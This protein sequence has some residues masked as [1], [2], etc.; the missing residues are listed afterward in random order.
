[1]LTTLEKLVLLGGLDGLNDLGYEDL[2]PLAELSREL[3][4]IPG[5]VISSGQSGALLL[6]VEGKLEVRTGETRLEFGSLE[7]LGGLEVLGESAVKATALEETRILRIEGSALSDLLRAEPE[8]SL[9]LLVGLTR[10][11]RGQA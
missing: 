11:L 6:I 5:E 4:I 2:L 10:E 3:L 7:M 8:L 9:T 1:M